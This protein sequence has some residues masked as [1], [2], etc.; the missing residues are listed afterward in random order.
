MFLI[1]R[2][3]DLLRNMENTSRKSTRAR[4]D[5]EEVTG[6]SKLHIVH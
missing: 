3:V 5:L 6:E 4:E 2:K 1:V